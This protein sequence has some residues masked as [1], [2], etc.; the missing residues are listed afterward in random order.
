MVLAKA[1]LKKLILFKCLFFKGVQTLFDT[2]NYY[3]ISKDLCRDYPNV[4]HFCL[5]WTNFELLVYQ[6]LERLVKKKVIW[7]GIAGPTCILSQLN[8]FTIISTAIILG[9]WH[10]S[11]FTAEYT[12]AQKD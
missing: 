9:P 4:E 6:C 1:N 10:S 3:A 12:K 7:W 2:S 11:H 5:E 8:T